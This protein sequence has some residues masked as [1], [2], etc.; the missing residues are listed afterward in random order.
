MSLIGAPYACLVLE[1]VLEDVRD[2]IS[3]Q[4]SFMANFAAMKRLRQEMGC[5]KSTQAITGCGE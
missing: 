2:K 3:W 5:A 4:N 1:R